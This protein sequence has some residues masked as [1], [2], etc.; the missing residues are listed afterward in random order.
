MPGPA[1][2]HY[3]ALLQS[4]PKV[5]DIDKKNRHIVNSTI[6]ARG[7]AISKIY[8]FL[9]LNKKRIPTFE[10]QISPPETALFDE[11]C[12]ALEEFIKFFNKEN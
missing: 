12:I 3:I 7:Q 1:I 5:E 9:Y 2:G 8:R 11:K 6:D 10:Y 4:L